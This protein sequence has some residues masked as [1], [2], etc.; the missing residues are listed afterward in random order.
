MLDNPTMSPP[1]PPVIKVQNESF[2]GNVRLAKKSLPAKRAASKRTSKLDLGNSSVQVMPVIGA[3]GSMTILPA[4]T[5]L[6]PCPLNSLSRQPAREFPS[7]IECHW[8][9]S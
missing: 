3:P 6:V 2:T 1:Q 4:S 7:N 5:W 8:R 9:D